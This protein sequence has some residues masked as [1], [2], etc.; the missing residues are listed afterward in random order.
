VASILRKTGVRSR[1]DF[2][3]RYLGSD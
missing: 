3:A 1:A 2:V